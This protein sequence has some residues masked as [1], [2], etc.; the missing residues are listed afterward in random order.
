[1][2]GKIYTVATFIEYDYYI[3]QWFKLRFKSKE[4][5]MVKNKP[6]FAYST[7]EATEKYK[8]RY[9]WESKMPFLWDGEARSIKRSVAVCSE[10]NNY[11][12]NRL[13]EEMNSQDFLEYCK[14]ELL[15]VSEIIK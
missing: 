9:D 12:F 8:S 14:Q 7:E 2:R 11:T 3:Y 1:M 5:D 13:K 10:H 4:T 6:V 15:G